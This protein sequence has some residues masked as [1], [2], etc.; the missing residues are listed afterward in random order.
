M[1]FNHR[2]GIQ[3]GSTAFS[4]CSSLQILEFPK[5]KRHGFPVPLPASCYLIAV[6]CYPGPTASPRAIPFLLTTDYRLLI[7][8]FCRFP[9]SIVSTTRNSAFP[10]VIRSYASFTFASGNFS[11]I[12]RTPEYAENSSVSCESIAVP[13]GQP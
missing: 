13:E 6:I 12:G 5:Q 11:T 4:L 7:T 1:A 10:D 9:Y 3:P 8:D 2:S